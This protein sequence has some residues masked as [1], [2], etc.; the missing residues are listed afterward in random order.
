MSL[1]KQLLILIS[2]LFLIIFSVNFALSVNNIRDYL[3]GEAKIHAQD[4]ATSLGLSLSSYLVD[5]T[6]P[7]IETTMKAIF[8]MGYYQEIK[9]VNV[10]DKPLVTLS[11]KLNIDGVP[12]WFI[13]ML[14]ME[15]VRVESEISSGWSISGVLSVT[16]NPGYAYS[17][18]YEQAKHGFYYS[19]IIFSLS[20]G[21]LLFVLRVTLS[22][23]KKIDQMALTIASGKFEV[24]E[25]LP[26]TTEVKNVTLSMN[27]MSS[28]IEAIINGLN[29]KLNTIGKKLQQ[30]DLTGLSK[31]SSFETEMNKLFESQKE[32]NAFIFMIKIDGLSSLVKE[33]GHNMI[34]QFIKD[35]AD[36]LTTIAN[37]CS[38]E[39][40]S[41]YRFF[42]SE[43]CLLVND[44]DEKA[45]ESIAQS[46]SLGFSEVGQKY[47]KI[48]IAHIG[49]AAFNPLGDTE[50]LL[51]AANE[52]YEQ[53]QLIGANSY[54]IRQTEDQAKD[55]AE[56]KT[57]IFNSIDRHEYDVSFIG[58][59]Y[60]MESQLLFMEDAFT[61]AFDSE[62]NPIAIGTF[63][64][65]AEKFA[66]IIELDKAVIEEVIAHIHTKPIRHAVA[67]S[68]STRTIKNG[69]FR[70]WLVELLEN[71]KGIA[72]QLVFSISSYAINKEITVFKEFIDFLHSLDT[73][74]MIKRFDVQSMSLDVVKHLHPDFVR[75][76]RD[77]GE[78]IS[79][80]ESKYAFVET[81]QGVG[82]L[83]DIKILAENVHNHQDF[84]S[85]KQIGL[86]ASSR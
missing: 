4:T 23:L 18:L 42:G 12:K 29:T 83:L 15:T 50:E 17:K 49:V 55:I 28:K 66:K 61:S 58:Q 20:V 10:E 26:W 74:V 52:A 57:L 45:I 14:P 22:P 73:K 30:D 71:N 16:L 25:Q 76:T 13:K 37:Q 9:L 19:L 34:D 40:I 2:A 48:D 86:I 36:V 68:L 44:R 79:Q 62:G 41:A 84:Q 82:K 67:I 39:E 21:F 78:N 46:L 33:L 60:H 11:H 3:E 7:M 5:E 24:I 70:T 85:I 72:P 81:M 69:D 6:D 54:Y 32:V 59:S 64:S 35:F 47:K 77:L 38:D 1:S 65:I 63:I 51:L 31:K 8:D 27:M 53:A 75:L 80:D 43:F 56:W